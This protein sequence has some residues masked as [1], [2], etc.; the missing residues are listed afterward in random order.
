MSPHKIP[1][2]RNIHPTRKMAITPKTIRLGREKFGMSGFVMAIP[3]HASFQSQRSLAIKLPHMRSLMA[4]ADS[5]S[6]TSPRL[7]KLVVM[8]LT[9]CSFLP[10]P[11]AADSPAVLTVAPMKSPAGTAAQIR[12]ELDRALAIATGGFI[13]QL[14]PAIFGPIT[15]VQIFSA[16]G[17]ALGTAI[18]QGT[19]ADVRFSAISGTIGRLGGLPIATV[20]AMVLSEASEG[21][22]A[23][24]T[25]D[26]ALQPWQDA[27][28]ST[29]TLAAAGSTLTVGGQL[30]LQSIMPIGPGTYWISRKAGGRISP[31]L[32]DDPREVPPCCNLEGLWSWEMR[33][34]VGEVRGWRV[35]DTLIPRI[36]NVVE[37]RYFGGLMEDEIVATL[38]I[39]PCTV[40]R[41]WDFAQ[42]WLVRE[43]S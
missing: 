28:G 3:E 32:A 8:G 40:R 15:D 12:V 20:T 39:S 30:T 19:R 22:S 13:I 9:A 16:A 18:L 4:A 26:P 7:A 21:A 33:F 38:K 34:G 41:D 11:A 25:L 27:V 29:M 6:L 2:I 35:F 31:P 37:L 24:I 1:E 17:D 5:T 42:A 36:A 23:T 43:L 10:A 14:D